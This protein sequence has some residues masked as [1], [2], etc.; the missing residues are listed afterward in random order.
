MGAGCPVSAPKPYW[1]RRA[2]AQR[3]KQWLCIIVTWLTRNTRNMASVD[4]GD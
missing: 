2:I 4:P 3:V 1:G